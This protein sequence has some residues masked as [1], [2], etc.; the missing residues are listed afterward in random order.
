MYMSAIFAY[1]VLTMDISRPV[2]LT[3]T[4]PLIMKVKEYISTI[5]EV[6]ACH[7]SSPGVQK[8][9]ESREERMTEGERENGTAA[10]LKLSSTQVVVEFQLSSLAQEVSGVAEMES[11]VSLEGEVARPT[12][13]VTREGLVLVWDHMTLAY[14]NVFGHGEAAGGIEWLFT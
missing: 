1:S 4:S 8:D 9:K 14:P 11:Y 3:V 13:S 12:D 10:Q 5:L 7:S 6:T 2:K